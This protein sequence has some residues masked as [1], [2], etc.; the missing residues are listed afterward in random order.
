M[1]KRTVTLLCSAL[2]AVVVAGST[3]SITALRTRDTTFAL[4][5]DGETLSYVVPELQ[6]AYRWHLSVACRPPSLDEVTV[7]SDPAIDNAYSGNPAS[8]EGLVN[9]LRA[10]AAIVD[11]HPSLSTV[12]IAAMSDLIASGRPAVVVVPQGYWP[13]AVPVPRLRA[14]LEAGGV[15]IWFGDRLGGWLWTTAGPV[16][17]TV[18]LDEAL[19]GRSLYG[20]QDPARATAPLPPEQQAGLAFRWA[21]QGVSPEAVVVLGGRVLGWQTTDGQAVSHAVLPLGQGRVVVF[22]GRL[23]RLRGRE[24]EAAQDIVTMLS[25]G[26]TDLDALIVSGTAPGDPLSGELRPDPT[27][28]EALVVIG[29]SDR[30]VFRFARLRWHQAVEAPTTAKEGAP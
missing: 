5:W 17:A 24:A 18:P 13:E 15:L 4:S 23:A 14:W 21:E 8:I 30:W 3:A 2:F 28:P 29:S 20:E 11:W 25:R 12:T 19:W 10:N 6:F 26:L 22:G 16:Q 9:H 1:Y 7:L 27:C